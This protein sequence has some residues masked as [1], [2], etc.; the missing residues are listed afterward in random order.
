MS[1]ITKKVKISK[2]QSRECFVD[3]YRL[4]NG[5]SFEF[6]TS[7]GADISL[8]NEYDFNGIRFY[9]YKIKNARF[10]L[11]RDTDNNYAC[12]VLGRD[13]SYRLTSSD[14]AWIEQHVVYFDESLKG[15]DTE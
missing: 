9:E 11:T 7:K 13:E 15:G 5:K 10:V 8:T 12:Y 6:L 4:E 1:S 2:T 14:W 3:K